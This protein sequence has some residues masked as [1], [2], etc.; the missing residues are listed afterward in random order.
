VPVRKGKRKNKI[1]LKK[2]LRPKQLQPLDSIMFV[3]VVLE[4]G[5]VVVRI[6]QE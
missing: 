2:S 1:D 3:V 4:K 6:G 5:P